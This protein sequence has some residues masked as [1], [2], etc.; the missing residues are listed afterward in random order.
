MHYYEL[1]HLASANLVDEFDTEA[2]A[3]EA[4]L[5]LG[6]ATGFGLARRDERSSTEWSARDADVAR[7]AR[8]VPAR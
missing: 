4:V 3:L 1:W 2:G 6:D 5:E 8:E 7:L